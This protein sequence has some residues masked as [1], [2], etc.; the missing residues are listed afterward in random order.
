MAFG[1]GEVMQILYVEREF[2]LV[3]DVGSEAV[4]AIFIH[5][6]I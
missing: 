5:S 4:Y 3:T 1:Q 6:F 2:V